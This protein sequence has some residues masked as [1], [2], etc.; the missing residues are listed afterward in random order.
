M[1][2]RGLIESIGRNYN[3]DQGLT[4]PT[5]TLLR[6]CS[7]EMA[8]WIPPGYIAHGSGGQGIPAFVPWIGVFDPDETISAQRGMY[9][10]YLF[11]VQFGTVVL[12]LNQGVTDLVQRF[13]TARGRELLARQ[14]TAIRDT[15]PG[16]ATAGLSPTIDL[17]STAARPVHYRHG[18]IVAKTYSIGDLPPAELMA[19]DLRRFVTL[20]E[21]ALDAREVLRRE[22]P[23]LVVTGVAE[24]KPPSVPQPFVSQFKPKDDVDYLA[25]VA[26]LSLV[27]TRKHE[28]LVREYGQRLI[29][30][31]FQPA[32]N[33]HPRD[34]LAVKD[35]STWLIEAKMVRRG[36][37]IGAAREALGQ[38]VAYKF[39][40]HRNESIQTLAVFSED[41]GAL[42]V[43]LLEAYG[44]A[45][46]WRDGLIWAGSSRAQMNGL[47]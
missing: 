34:M 35:D 11:A 5:Q 44:I 46:V 17:P 40:H 15:L 8:P 30:L 2:L 42:S 1:D 4:S 28:T 26:A 16:G 47:C 25:Q 36:N 31:G 41:V 24:P 37:G 6:H 13:K 39:L 29:T 22:R 18:N 23:E 20:Y 14:A 19:A 9:V 32:T 33:V 38:L 45:A 7:T 21:T 12:S 27:K 3:P 10:V 43:G